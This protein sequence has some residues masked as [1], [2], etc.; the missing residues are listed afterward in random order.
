MVIFNSE[1]LNYQRIMKHSLPRGGGV[2]MLIDLI[3]VNQKYQSSH[4]FRISWAF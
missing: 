1:L 3:V 4:L 2:S